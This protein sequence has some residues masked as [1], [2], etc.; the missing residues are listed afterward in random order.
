MKL[1]VSDI[2]TIGN[3]VFV[4]GIRNINIAGKWQKRAFT[5]VFDAQ[6]FADHVKQLKFPIVFDIKLVKGVGAQFNE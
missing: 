5:T 3:R 4:E 2:K 1:H 6:Y